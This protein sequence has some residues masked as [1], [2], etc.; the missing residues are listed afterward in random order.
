MGCGDTQNDRAMIT[1]A[2][3]RAAGPVAALLLYPER[4]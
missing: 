3:A 1:Y 4:P 2:T